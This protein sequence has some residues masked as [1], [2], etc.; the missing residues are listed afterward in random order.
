[1]ENNMANGYWGHVLFVDLSAGTVE[2][3]TVADETYRQYLGGYGLAARILYEHIPPA[4]DPLGP[5]NVLAF[6]PGLLTGSGAPF[7]GRFMV[8]AKSPLTGGWGDANGGGRFGPALRATGYDGVFVRGVSARPVYLYLDGQRAELRD[9]AALWGLDTVAT[10][11]AI[12]RATFPDV[13]VACIGP[14]GEKRSLIS[15]IVNDGG[16]IAA[17]CGLGAV[18]GAKNLKAVAA[19]GKGS[20][21]LADKAAFD[22]STK[23][24]RDLFRKK[25]VLWASWVHRFIHVLA[26]L[27]G[28]LHMQFSGGPTQMVIDNFR[29]YGTSAGTALQV[30]VGDTPI[31]N[32]TGS[33]ATDYPVGLAVN[34]SDEA[35]IRDKIKPYACHSCPL[36]CGGVIRLPDGGTGL[37]PEYETL[38]AFGPTVMNSDLATVVA[39]N[40]ICNLAGLDS[41]SAGVTVAFALECYERGWLSPELAGEIELCWGDDK[42]IV[43]LTRRIAAR[44]PGLGDWLADGVRR[45]AQRLGPEAQAAAMHA[46]GQELAMHRGLYEPN[47]AAGY[48]MDPAPGRHTATN[49]GIANAPVVLR[50]LKLQGRSLS[51]RYD[52][53]AKG[54]ETATLMPVLRALD[55]LGLCMFSLQFGELPFVAWLRAA[56]GW[57]VDEAELLRTGQRIQALRH[58]FNAREG[59]APTGVTLPG[60]ERGEPSPTGDPLAGVTLDMDT[61][62]QSYCQAL[63]IDRA[64]GWPLAE[65]ARALDLEPLLH[66]RG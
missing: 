60:R 14:A 66:T 9:A 59:I 36:A 38:A 1:V 63:G 41:I 54:A 51:G 43:E 3:R 20:P 17:R 29:L 42:A 39:C 31:R 28:R 35:V 6:M 16:R 27:M 37:R 47:V 58:A 49:S 23:G 25:P 34:L 55:A 32:W 18:M 10:E 40:E 44:Q 2:V 62:A 53:A 57:D 19:R 64:T 12:A 48:Q 50:Y 65:T 4:A 33:S 30:A 61:M 22:A 45:A 46:G 13:H 26:P 5:D 21:Q 7:S 52:Y 24:Y 8:A 56:T 15:G 11:E